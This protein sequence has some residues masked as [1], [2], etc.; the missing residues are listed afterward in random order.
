MSLPTRLKAEFREQARR[1]IDSDRS[2]R[3]AGRSQNTI[4][5]IAR[6]LERAYRAGLAG[7]GAS[8]SAAHQEVEWVMLPPRARQALE[9]LG[10]S[11]L[12]ETTQTALAEI[13]LAR[14]ESGPE[15]GRWQ[16]QFGNHVGSWTLSQGAM[17]PLIKLGVIGPSL[18]EAGRLGLTLL[19]LKIMENYLRRAREGDASLPLS[20]VGSR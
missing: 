3:K 7:S 9:Y 12:A 14:L 10:G 16:A 13:T 6:A 20:S 1:I 19:G 2:A 17:A 18:T 11:P 8:L 15:L 4:G 5:E